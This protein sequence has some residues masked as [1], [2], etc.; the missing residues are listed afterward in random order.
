MES[1]ESFRGPREEKFVI[2]TPENATRRFLLRLGLIC[3]LAA[4]TPKESQALEV[5]LSTP[6]MSTVTHQSLVQE[7][8]VPEEILSTPEMNDMTRQVLAQLDNDP[9]LAQEETPENIEIIKTVV[10]NFDPERVDSAITRLSGVSSES[11]ARERIK[12]LRFITRHEF[13][14]FTEKAGIMVHEFI[15]TAKNDEIFVALPFVRRDEKGAID[16]RDLLNALIHE[17]NHI[18]T[19]YFGTTGVGGDQIRHWEK[20]GVSPEFFEGITELMAQHITE[21]IDG[22]PND[23]MYGNGEFLAAWLMEQV[24]GTETLAHGYF[25]DDFI[26]IRK[27]FDEKMGAGTA[28]TIFHNRFNILAKAFVGVPFPEGIV[29]AHEFFKICNA[30]NSKLAAELPVRAQMD[31]LR[32]VFDYNTSANTLFHFKE[33]DQ[34]PRVSNLVVEDAIPVTKHSFPLRLALVNYEFKGH[35]TAKDAEAIANGIRIVTKKIEDTHDMIAQELGVKDIAE[36]EEGRRVFSQMTMEYMNATNV[37]INV[38]DELREYDVTYQSA[39]TPDE[40]K[41][42]QEAIQSEM[43]KIGNEIISSIRQKVQD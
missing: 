3:G 4:L 30:K 31:G 26:G 12:N 40:R 27:A 8:Q 29:A 34:R 6:E 18:K 25:G 28:D 14:D 21:E 39:K 15:A 23:Q 19:S 32:E 22:R 5:V 42:V 37:V 11:I 2:K 38:A 43:I 35:S 16:Q 24:A 36:S 33:V 13:A 10:K 9:Y 7:T 17:N 41:A 1:L 20:E